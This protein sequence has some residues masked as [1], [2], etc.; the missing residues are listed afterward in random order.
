MVG[1]VKLG[2]VALL[3]TVLAG[4]V[5]AAGAA[6]SGPIGR[7]GS[8]AAESAG[9]Y[10]PD[11]EEC[12]FLRIINDFRRRHGQD[13][14]VLLETLGAAAIHHSD[15]MADHDYFSHTLKGERISWSANIKKHNYRGSP[16]GENIA[17]GTNMDSAGVAFN[18]WEDSSGHRKNMLDPDFEAIG[19]GRAYKQSAEYDWYW[20][21]TFGGDVDG[22]EANC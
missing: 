8:V 3:A 5:F 17:A 21:T 7:T 22:K 11:D 6:T 19:I 9:Q 18:A 16:T 1:A 2:R 13:E 4:G 10:N 14:L 15:D 20:T 12:R